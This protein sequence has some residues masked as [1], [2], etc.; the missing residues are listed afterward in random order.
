MSV[1][2]LLFNDAVLWFVIKQKNMF[3]ASDSVCLL[4]EL[5][6]TS[7]FFQIRLCIFVLG[8]EASATKYLLLCVWMHDLDV[9]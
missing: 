6:D 8:I 5:C 9:R 2:L 7:L 3:I 1:A 4:S